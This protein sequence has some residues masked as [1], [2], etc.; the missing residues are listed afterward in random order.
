MRVLRDFSF[1][2]VTEGFLIFKGEKIIGSLI[3]FFPTIE[4]E[5]RSVSPVFLLCEERIRFVSPFLFSCILILFFFFAFF[6]R[7]SRM[8]KDFQVYGRVN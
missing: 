3:F 7:F 8:M 2:R 5:Q 1:A 4:R 6:Q